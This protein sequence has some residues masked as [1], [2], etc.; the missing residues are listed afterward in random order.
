MRVSVLYVFLK[1][2]IVRDCDM[3]VRVCIEVINEWQFC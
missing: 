1:L 3:C 2:E